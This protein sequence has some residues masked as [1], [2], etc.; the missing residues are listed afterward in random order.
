MRALPTWAVREHGQE[1]ALLNRGLND[2]GRVII[3]LNNRAPS[4]EHR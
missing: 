2:G 4:T 1:P 3:F